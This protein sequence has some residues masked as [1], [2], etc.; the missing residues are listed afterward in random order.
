MMLKDAHVNRC[1]N[2]RKVAIQCFQ[3]FLGLGSLREHY[4]SYV[5]EN[6][7]GIKENA[8]SLSACVY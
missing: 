4:L 7:F 3:C 2:Q 6:W 8:V 1:T 5:A